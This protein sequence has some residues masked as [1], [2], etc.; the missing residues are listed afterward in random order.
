M[1]GTV[2]LDQRQTLCQNDFLRNQRDYIVRV[3]ISGKPEV[4]TSQGK[5]APIYQDAVR[6]QQHL[7]RLKQAIASKESE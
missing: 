6:Y 4:L 3:K 1:Q 2:M 5:P 7:N